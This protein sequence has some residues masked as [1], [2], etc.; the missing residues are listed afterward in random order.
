M[1][2]I[3]R[4]ES[5]LIFRSIGENLNQ[6]TRDEEKRGGGEKKKKRRGGKRGSNLLEIPISVSCK[7]VKR[8]MRHRSRFITGTRTFSRQTK[9][10]PVLLWPDGRGWKGG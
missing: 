3:R 2:K 6:V 5:R 8:E 1:R 4:N 7:T 10:L 9:I